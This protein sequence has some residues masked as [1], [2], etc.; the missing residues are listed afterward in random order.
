MYPLDCGPRLLR[1]HQLHGNM[2]PPN[3]QDAIFLLHF[4]GH[5]RRQPSIAGINLTRIQR[6]SE[7]AHHSTGGPGDDVINRGGVRFG[8]LGG[9][10][11]VVRGNR[12]ADAE[13]YWLRFSRQMGHSQRPCFTLDLNFRRV[14]HF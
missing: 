9:I 4:P 10:N 6:A 13:D 8:D 7:C 12:P 5:I 2:N 14:N 3:Y 1:R 11:L